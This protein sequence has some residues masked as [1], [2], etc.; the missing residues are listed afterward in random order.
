MAVID[1]SILINLFLH[2]DD[3]CALVYA[4]EQGSVDIMNLL[5][6]NGVD[7][8][9]QLT[10]FAVNWSVCYRRELKYLGLVEDMAKIQAFN[11]DGTF[12]LLL[13]NGEKQER[14]PRNEISPCVL[15]ALMVAVLFGQVS[16]AKFLLSVGCDVNYKDDVSNCDYSLV[17]AYL[18]SCLFPFSV[19]IQP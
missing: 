1:M 3:K 19:I 12:D 13:G 2:Q 16:A 14:V 10:C 9:Q 7:A 4:I 11:S 15:S 6:A 5:L 17:T 8:N 18:M